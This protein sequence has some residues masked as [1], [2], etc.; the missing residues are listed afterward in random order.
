MNQ[1]TSELV[2]RRND[3][4]LALSMLA[5]PAF[6]RL[7]HD[8]LSNGIIAPALITFGKSTSCLNSHPHPSSNIR[9]TTQSPNIVYVC[10]AS[11]PYACNI[12]IADEIII[13]LSSYT[14]SSITG[15]A[16]CAS[17]LSACFN[18]I[19]GG[20]V[21]ETL[22]SYLGTII[23][24]DRPPDVLAAAITL[25]M[26]V[27]LAAGVKKSLVFN[28]VLNVLNL[29]AWVFLMTAG[30]FY[31]DTDTWTNHGGFLPMGWS[32]VFSGAATCFYAFIGFDIIATT[33]EEA[34]NPKKSIPLAIVTSLAIILVAYVTSSLVLTLIIPYNEINAEAGLVAMFGQV[35]AN[36]CKCIIAAGG[37]AGLTV[38]MFGSMFPMPRIVYAMAH[39]GL[40]FRSLSQIFPATGTPVLATFICGVAAAIASL[41]IS[42]DVLVEMMSIGTLLAYTLV[43]TCV[44]ILRYQPHTTNLMEL[45][46]E[47][48][49]TPVKGSP[50]KPTAEPIG[51]ANGQ[52]TNIAKQ[53]ICSSQSEVQTSTVP[54]ATGSHFVDPSNFPSWDD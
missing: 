12:F 19:S 11:V 47:S 23:G 14:Y 53:T 45:L 18:T 30:V 38:S 24:T 50:M 6:S 20:A 9:K 22:K 42:L 7:R 21:S 28:N 37:V 13:S 4:R 16:A 10:N 52:A 44:L 3:Y 15:T 2:V 33:G 31:I 39:D 43:S 29:S 25:C 17:A 49:R 1:N 51:V 26:M 32:G 36:R 46:P 40:I 41:I 54:K 34:T 5:T 35:G 27:L 48:L 8:V